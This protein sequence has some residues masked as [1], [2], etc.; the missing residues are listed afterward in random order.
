[1]GRRPTGT[2]EPLKSSIRLK[3]TVNGTRCVQTLDLLPT[4]ANIKA[5]ERTLARIMAAVTAGI[6]RRDDFFESAGKAATE[7]FSAYADAWLETMTL[8]AS[9]RR[10]YSGGINSTWKPAFGDKRLGEIRHSDVK[11]A[12]A[13]K[14][15]TASA[16][17]INNALVSLRGIFDT[18]M[19]DGLIRKDPTEGV[20]NLKHQAAEADPFER[21]EVDA[22]L[23]HMT[24]FPEQVGNYFGFAFDTGMRPSELIALQWGDVDWKRET[25]RV[26]RAVVDWKEKGTKTNKV[27]DVALSEDALAALKRQK[28]HTFMRGPEAAIFNN[29]NTGRPWADEQVQRRLYYTPTLRA[30]G[31]RHRD[32]YQTRH[33]F[34]TLLLM[35][36]INPTWIAKQLGHTNALMLFKVYG[37]WIEGADKGAEAAK[38][39][40]VLSRNRPRGETGT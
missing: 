13:T 14:R 26:Q 16:K 11:T 25:I 15:K 3:F 6:Y 31:L 9:S 36:G 5:A 8:E 17:T 4:P 33:T 24:R 28:A 18:A 38:A 20:G 10:G 7:T 34:A 19:K 37:T 21:H 1:M 29:P 30:L 39:K 27:R 35:G 2:V 32:M 40:A 23:S 22:I 12:I